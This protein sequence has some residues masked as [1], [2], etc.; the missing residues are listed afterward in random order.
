[1]RGPMVH[2]DLQA[3]FLIALGIAIIVA[4]IFLTSK[5][6]ENFID[7]RF[8]KVIFIVSLLVS[9]F[10]MPLLSWFAKLASGH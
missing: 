10:F 3:A 9:A 1:V 6:A 8:E 5:A 4:P 7:R 2:F